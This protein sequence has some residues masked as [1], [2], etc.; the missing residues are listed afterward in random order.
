MGRCDGRFDPMF[1]QGLALVVRTQRFSISHLQRH[2]CIGYRRAC[3]L[4]AAIEA[5]N[6]VKREI[7]NTK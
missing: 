7:G 4:M 1:P 2:L 5:T 3:R 6:L